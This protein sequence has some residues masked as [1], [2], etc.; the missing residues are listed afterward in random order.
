MSI[1]SGRPKKAVLILLDW[2]FLHYY[3]MPR[4]INGAGIVII[5]SSACK[6]Q[7]K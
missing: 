2:R 1:L 3:S 5:E 7:V 6:T 4:G